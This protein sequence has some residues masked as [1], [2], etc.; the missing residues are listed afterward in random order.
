MSQNSYI[1]SSFYF[2]KCRQLVF[3]KKQKFPLF[4]SLKKKDLCQSSETLFPPYTCFELVVKIF[5]CEVIEIIVKKLPFHLSFS[6]FSA[7][8]R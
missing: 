8:V 5:E 7:I 2:I 1:G 6:N 4:F 3:E